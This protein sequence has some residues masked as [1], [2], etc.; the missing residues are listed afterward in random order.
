MS[1]P[2]DSPTPPP[3]S[4]QGFARFASSVAY[5]AAAGAFTL[6]ASAWAQILGS[7]RTADTTLRPVATTQI[8]ARLPGD[9]KALAAAWSVPLAAVLLG[10]LADGLASTDPG[11]ATVIDLERNGRAALTGLDL[12]DAVGWFT[13]HHPIRIAHTALSPASA[14]ALAASLAGVPDTGLSYGV[15]RFAGT[16]IQGNQCGRFAVN[17]AEADHLPDGDAAQAA[18]QLRRCAVSLT[19][20]NHLPYEGT[21]VFRPD[22]DGVRADLTFDPRR[23]SDADARALLAAVASAPERR[24]LS[25]LPAGS[26][27]H[28]PFRAAIPASA[29]QQMMLETACN[30][31]GI[32]RPRQIITFSGLP[33]DHDAF[34]AM[35]CSLLGQLDP[36]R[37]RFR[38][39]AAGIE[40]YREPAQPVPVRRCGGGAAAA[41]Q[42]LREADGIDAEAAA[43]GEALAGLIAFEAPGEPLRLGMQI[44]HAIIDGPSN[45]RLIALINDLLAAHVA[46]TPMATPGSEPSAIAIRKHTSAELA[47]TRARGAPATGPAPGQQAQ[48]R[49][50]P[51]PPGATQKNLS[52]AAVGQLTSWAQRQ[53]VDIRAVFAAAALAVAYQRAP[54]DAV[55]LVSNGR[56]PDIPDTGDALGMFWYFQPI[57]PQTDSIATLAAQVFTLAARPIREVREAALGWRDW[58]TGAG[59]AFNFIK[60][61]RSTP[62]ARLLTVEAGRDQFHFPTHIEVSLRADGSAQINWITSAGQTRKSS[63]PDFLWALGRACERRLND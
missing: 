56:D 7:G 39:T 21:L 61:E 34:L 27:W 32:Y 14:S 46:G 3:G 42:W 4:D 45:R 63:L 40:Q 10:C 53:A 33:G 30:G 29:M 62:K 57:I 17:I 13:I 58:P 55:Y 22:Q 9:P 6:D 2:Q 19:G 11:G 12:S 15:L 26:A 49:A 1:S 36:F 54:G 16:A 24:P 41:L 23:L 35:L 18:D 38:R 25:L 8:S 47:I 5:Q 59:I 48:I 50:R 52:A 31:P 43:N 44:H 37:R 28:D 51:A 60:A 20:R